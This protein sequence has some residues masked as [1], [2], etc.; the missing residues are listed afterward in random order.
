[1]QRTKSDRSIFG[2]GVQRICAVAAASTAL[3]MKEQVLVGLRQTPTIELR[4]DWLRNDAERARLLAWVKRRKSSGI[5]FIATCRR[6]EGG[7]KL[8]RG[9]DAE[10][11]WL[12]EARNAGCGWC[13][14]EIETLRRLRGRNLREL[15][16]PPRILLSVHDFDRMPD[17]HSKLD[18]AA[19][20]RVDAV[21]IA[22]NARTIADS[23]RLLELARRA[24]NLVA[25][26]MGEVGLPARILAL[27]A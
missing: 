1:M 2:T 24:R 19:T 18:L 27:R 21:K 26:P 13:D 12:A 6:K 11:Y 5:R 15:R 14:L 7:G 16:L 9:A 22:A 8:T 10:L 4:L 17:L 3:E 25:V 23:A 20:D